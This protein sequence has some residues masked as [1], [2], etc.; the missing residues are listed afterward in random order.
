MRM[1]SSPTR[2]PVGELATT[3]GALSVSLKER[4]SGATRQ[5]VL[6]PPT[7]FLCQ[8]GPCTIQEESSLGRIELDSRD[9]L[10]CSA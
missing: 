1:V 6:K 2:L 9:P 5:G 4:Y 3:S 7:P 8:K 10:A